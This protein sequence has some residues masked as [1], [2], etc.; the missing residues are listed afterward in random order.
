MS[1]DLWFALGVSL[2]QTLEMIFFATF[3]ALILGLPIGIAL[4]LTRTGS[5]AEHPW[6]YKNLTFIVNILRSIPFIILLVLLIPVTRILVGTSIGT[7]AA[8]VPLSIGAAPFIARIIDN[9]LQE[10][11]FGL[12]EAGIAMGMT[13][14]QIVLRILLP[15]SYVGI[16]NGLTL[17]VVTLVGYSAMAGAVGGGGLGDLAI[18]YGYNM[19]NTTL[20]FITVALLVIMVQGIQFFG[21]RLAKM[22]G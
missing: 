4:F 19:F 13:R 2:I 10:V 12:I 18:Q 9:A 20:M 17:T 21:E 15:E 1:S 16:V 5:L 7:A 6:L 22:R 14:S 8:I 11:P 3:F